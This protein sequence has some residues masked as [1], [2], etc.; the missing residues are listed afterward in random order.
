[1][2]IHIGYMLGLPFAGIAMLM[3]IRFLKLSVPS[4]IGHLSA[5]T[6]FFI[7]KWRRGDYGRIRPVLMIRK[8]PDVNDALVSK[9]GEQIFVVRNR[10]AIGFLRTLS[11]YSFLQIDLCH[12]V[13]TE[14]GCPYHAVRAETANDPQ[15]LVLSEADKT[16]CR[17]KLATLGVP[18]GR[19]LVAVHPR[20]GGYRN[21][22]YPHRNAPLASFLPA[23]D[24]IV[25]QGGWCVRMGDPTGS[26]SGHY[27]LTDYA[28][29]PLK[30]NLMDV[31]ICGSSRFFLGCA[32]GLSIVPTL[33]GRPTVVAHMV[34]LGATLPPDAG[35]IAIPKLM[36]GSDSRILTFAEMA[37][38]GLTTDISDEL[39][40]NAGVK[41][42][43]SDPVDI[44][45]ACLE[46][47]AKLDGR[48]DIG[49]TDRKRQER[50]RSHLTDNDYCVYSAA[51]VSD[52]FLRK[53]EFLL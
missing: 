13:M 22:A 7:R 35:S 19:W 9:I 14:H 48:G 33:F 24:E 25:A 36:H 11:R 21:G 23:V 28:L 43:D 38:L 45:D 50:F 39:L 29:S 41:P 44:R 17:E 16:F 37:A 31:L 53:Y 34:P 47:I 52:A 4:A 2:G 42:I 40:C 15:S 32:S 27:G 10:V 49:P 5:E 26:D 51:R 1:M 46:M 30:S 3:G 18:P 12:A 8:K 20:E 6:D